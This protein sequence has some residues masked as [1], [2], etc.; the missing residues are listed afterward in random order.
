VGIGG[1]YPLSATIMSEYSNTRTRGAFIAAVFSMQGLGLLTAASAALAISG[2]LNNKYP[3]PPFDVNPVASVNPQGDIAWRILV[4]LGAVPATATFYY[5]LRMPETARYTALVER[6]NKQAAIDMATV[7]D[8]EF[9]G[10]D[11]EPSQEHAQYGFGSRK[12]WRLHLLHLIGTCGCWFIFDISYYSQNLFQQT[13]YGAIGWLPK[14]TTVSALEEM[15]KASRAQA[16]IAL[17]GT[18]PGYYVA[19]LLIDVIGRWI[20]QLQGF[21]FMS[22]FM[23]ALAIPYNHWV[24]H[25]HVGFIIIYGLTFFFSNFGPNTTTF[26]VPAEIYPARFRS[27][28]HGISA[29]SG[30]LGA[31]VGA[32][33]FN[34][35]AQPKKNPPVGY[36]PGIGLQDAIFILASINA[37]GFFLTFLVPETNQKSLEDLTGENDDDSPDSAPRLENKTNAA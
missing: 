16:L 12:F 28:C 10:A 4:M 8:V 35:V 27:T 36:P 9:K 3:A 32:F 19:I 25:D 23:F 14:N 31:I 21:F 37:I 24:N 13:V 11:L 26:I 20:I 22:V 5:R 2:G 18:V 34:Y 30:K 17:C 7:L 29:A 6:N 1:D 15:Y 33:G